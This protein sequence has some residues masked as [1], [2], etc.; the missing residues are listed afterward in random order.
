ME[1]MVFKADYLHS[2]SKP[3]RLRELQLL[4]EGFLSIMSIL[5][6]LFNYSI[7]KQGNGSQLALVHIFQTLTSTT[8][9]I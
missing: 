7:S 2:Q 9:T 3:D 5:V 6:K 8:S 1:Q 4:V